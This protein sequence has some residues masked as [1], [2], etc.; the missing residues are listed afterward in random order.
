[1]PPTVR[2]AA[3]YRLYTDLDLAK[4]DLIR[5]LRDAGV[6]LAVIARPSPRSRMIEMPGIRCRDSARFLDVLGDDDVHARHRL[7]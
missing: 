5:A 6:E 2:S 4:L 7:R 3:N 1:L